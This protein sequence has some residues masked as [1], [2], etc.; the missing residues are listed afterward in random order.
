MIRMISPLIT[1]EC[2]RRFRLALA[3]ALPLLCA[4]V[5]LPADDL[6]KSNSAA[7]V[8]LKLDLPAPVF[9]GTTKDAPQGVDMEPVPKNPP[10]PLSIPAD[11]RN[12]APA[13]KISSSDHGASAA[14]LSKI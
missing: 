3:C 12:L 4:A 1:L 10:P 8:P 14:R 5:N 9:A 2:F 13:A 11:V 7:L 6:A